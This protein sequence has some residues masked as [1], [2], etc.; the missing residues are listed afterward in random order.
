MIIVNTHKMVKQEQKGMKMFL[1]FINY[2]SLWF[3]NKEIWD[4]IGQ[5]L[6]VKI[7]V[8]CNCK[9]SVYARNSDQNIS[10]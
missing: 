6:H 10:T 3:R 5:R 1:I 2:S 7:G 8:F 9:G 4:P